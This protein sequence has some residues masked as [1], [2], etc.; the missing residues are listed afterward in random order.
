MIRN[1]TYQETSFGFQQGITPGIKYLLIANV[2]VFLLQMI[3][4]VLRLERNLGLVPYAIVHSLAVWQVVTYM[5]LHGGFM[6]IFFNMFALY[7]FG[8]DL[9]RQWGTRE[10][11]KF[12]FVTGI[13][14]AVITFLLQVNSTIPVIGASGAIYGVLV[15]FAVL[16][17]NRLVYIWFLFPIKV[18]YLV[19]ALIGLGVLASWSQQSDGIAHFTHLGGALIGY[20]YL[21]ADWRMVHRLAPL[22][23]VFRLRRKGPKPVNTTR[24]PDELMDEVDRILDRITE[25]GGYENLSEREKKV[26]ESASKKLSERQK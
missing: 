23:K 4:P 6:H 16:Y 8:T 22:K 20:L 10:F 17:P 5:F 21:K 7:M 15:A 14:A 19:M 26:L 12:Y 25:L 11:L 3:A 2:G 24:Q 13:G 9:E 18:K 1:S